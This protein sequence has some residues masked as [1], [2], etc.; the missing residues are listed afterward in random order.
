MGT[1][2]VFVPATGAGTDIPPVG[3]GT[4]LDIVEID[5][6]AA[7]K[8]EAGDEAGAGAGTGLLEAGA[9]AG[10]GAP[11]GATEG[12]EVVTDDNADDDGAAEDIGTVKVPVT[13]A[14]PGH[15]VQTVVVTVKPCGT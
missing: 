4:S 5:G 15:T 3:P 8:P 9:G 12:A 6:D 7:A 10:A 2:L 1:E 13:G 11:E 14:G